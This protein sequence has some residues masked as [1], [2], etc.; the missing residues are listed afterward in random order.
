MNR[1]INA[2]KS[3]GA[4][5]YFGYCPCDADSL[6]NAAKNYAWLRAY[7]ELIADIYDYDGVIGKCESYIYNHIYFFDCAF[8]LNDYGRTYRTYQLYLD[9]CDE[10]GV[11]AKYQINSLGTSFDGCKFEPKTT[12]KPKIP[13]DFLL[14]G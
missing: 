12:G 10:L 3:S 13:V 4:K 1:I 6:V 8:H 9:L 14:E 11:E 7:D 2:A 5:V